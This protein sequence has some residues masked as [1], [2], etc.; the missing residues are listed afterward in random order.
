M[1][2]TDFQLVT[3]KLVTPSFTERP[4]PFAKSAGGTGSPGKA[5]SCANLP[6]EPILHLLPRPG[7]LAQKRETGLHRGIELETADGNP[8]PHLAPAM[9]LH[10]LVDD[11]FQRDAVQWVQRM[12][13]RRSHSLN[14]PSLPPPRQQ[15]LRPRWAVPPA[16]LFMQARNHS[17]ADTKTFQPRSAGFQACRIAG[18]QTCVPWPFQ[19]AFK[20]LCAWIFMG[21]SAS[22]S[23]PNS[24]FASPPKTS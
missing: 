5:P 21:L 20:R 11:A 10:Q 3:T 22:L 17:S 4:S 19:P 15:F 18:L 14:F 9:P 8:P 23:K 13:N 12:R 6:N 16:P 1:Q 24:F 7:R 2:L